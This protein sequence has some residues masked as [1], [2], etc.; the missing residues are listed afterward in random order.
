MKDDDQRTERHITADRSTI[1]EWVDETSAEPTRRRR[2]DSTD[3][4]LLPTSEHGSDHERVDWD[5]FFEEMERDDR[6]VVADGDG[7]DRTLRV[8]DQD[9]AVRQSTMAR[10]D[11]TSS[12]MAGETVTTEVTETTVV[13]ETIVEHAD[14]ESELIDRSTVNETVLDAELV[15]RDLG[16]C[17]VKGLADHRTMRDAEMFDVGHSTTEEFDLTVEATEEWA[18]TKE[19]IEQA[20][21][22]SRVVDRDVEAT[23]DT[24]SDT[25]ESRIDLGDVERTILDSGI[26]DSSGHDANA[27]DEEGF[28]SEYKND[29]AVITEF[30]ER[31]TVEEKLSL[32]RVF[33]GTIDAA[34]SVT[35]RSR[36]VRKNV[37]EVELVLDWN[38]V[39]RRDGNGD[40]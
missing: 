34:V 20:A 13:E 9:D 23:A 37:E 28:R 16:E 6:V 31:K 32:D 5:T 1:R 24:Q 11:L 18:V 8:L 10:D 19:V 3:L 12:L 35:E 36:R 2:G 17:D 39:R 15:T 33:S 14:I 7:R 25:I 38:P 21:I 29:E 40:R 26:L 22:E 4:A 27:V 30:V